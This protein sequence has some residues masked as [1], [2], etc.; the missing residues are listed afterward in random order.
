[1]VNE[2][3]AYVYDKYLKFTTVTN[4]SGD[5]ILTVPSN[6]SYT[7]NMSCDITDIGKFST[8][9]PLLRT[10][11]YPESLFTEDGTQIN[12]D[13]PLERLPNID[14]QNQSITVKPLWS[15]DTSNT[16][17]GINRLDFNLIKRI[18]PFSTIVG[19]FFTQNSGTWWGDRIIFRVCYG[20]RNLCIGCNS[21][22]RLKDNWF[23]GLALKLK[24]CIRV[25]VAFTVLSW[26]TAF[27]FSFG[28]EPEF[29]PG[30]N[31]L[32]FCMQVKNIIP[33]FRILGL[34]VNKYC[35]FNGGKN[36]YGPFEFINLGATNKCDIKD[37]LS[38]ITGISDDFFIQSHQKG[39]LD[40]KVFNI[41]NSVK[42]SD[43]QIS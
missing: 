21:G 9:A 27:G 43:A 5:Y 15:Q 33:F 11:G 26:S 42:E 31:S 24:I 39:S 13:I 4:E 6:R 36:D 2:T 34:F 38:V 29:S 28:L 32:G 23:F 20:L 16:N 30:C 41:K 8:A 18:K 40:L 1:M 3:V 7:V 14:I 19:N 10:E 17:V 35:Q 12:E 37:A 25:D 22:T